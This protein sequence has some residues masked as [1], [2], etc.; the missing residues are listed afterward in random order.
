MDLSP[1]QLSALVAIADTGSFEAAAE[2][3]HVTP[4]AVSQRIRA[5]ES[6][7]GRVLVGRGTP[8]V[9]TEAG[10]PLVRL[11]RQLELVFAEAL[12]D[13]L[14]EGPTDL[15]LA[16]NADS[17]ATWFRPVLAEI[18]T[19]EGVALRLRVE[20]EGHS[21]DLLRRGEVVAAVTSDPS[22][23]QGCSVT[24]LGAM[25]YLPVA[26]PSLLR[27]G[28]ADWSGMPMVVFNAKDRLQHEELRRHT[29]V[30]PP[31]VH[32]VPS[33]DD[34]RA[35]IEAGLGWGLLP[36]AQARA[37]IEAGTLIRLGR[38]VTRVSLYWQRWRLD[39]ELLDRL[40][41]AVSTHSP[42]R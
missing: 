38:S 3:L 11:G 20:D 4:S 34:F 10:A 30:A 39:S 19:W 41:D 16:I 2:R 26:H 25:R 17:L 27:S 36:E 18:A 21:H 8:C 35:A 15:A 24:P 37:G 14:T 9:P 40:S 22:P 7:V 5:L 12:T 31:V 6:A 23:V 42:G 29:E 13:G 33:S 32:E 1:A 28:R